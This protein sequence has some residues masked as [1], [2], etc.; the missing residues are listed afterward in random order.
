MSGI[1]MALL[2]A[3]GLPPLTIVISPGSL[4]NTRVGN[5]SLTSGTA[6]G[7]ASGGSGTGYTYAWTYVSGDSYTINAPSSAATTFTT[8]LIVGIPKSGVYRCTVTDSLSNTTNATITVQME[9]T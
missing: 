9:A 2:G 3:A 6:T 8:S 7:S 5:G 4:F 1:Q